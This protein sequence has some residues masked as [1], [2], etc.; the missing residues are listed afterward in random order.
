M[1][2][3]KKLGQAN[4]HIPHEELILAKLIQNAGAF[5]MRSTRG[6]LY[7]NKHRRSLMDSERHKAVACCAMGALS[8]FQNDLNTS[9]L[10]GSIINGNDSSDSD[11]YSNGGTGYDVGR[12]FYL[13]RRNAS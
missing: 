3:L 10:T 9:A 4:D 6:A 1:G 5:G 12:C 7:R 13:A 8:L 11:Y 2:Y